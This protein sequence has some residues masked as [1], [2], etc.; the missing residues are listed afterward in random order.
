MSQ[1]ILIYIV[2]AFLSA[3]AFNCIP[4]N[5]NPIK[6]IFV[7]SVCGLLLSNLLINTCMPELFEKFSDA[8]PNAPTSNNMDNNVNTYANTIANTIA[9]ANTN[10]N[11]NT[12]ANII[13][14]T[15]ANANTNANT[16]T[17]SN[18]NI[19]MNT[20][21]DVNA[22]A[23]S[24][25][26]ANVLDSIL[27]KLDLEIKTKLLSYLSQISNQ[28]NANNQDDNT[29]IEEAIA[30]YFSKGK[31]IDERGMINNIINSD[32]K[33]NQLSPESLQPL[34]SYDNTFTNKWDHGFTYLSTDKWAPSKMQTPPVCKTEKQCP[35]CPIT[36]S[37]YPIGLMEFDN[38]RKVLG[39]DNIN[40]NYI[41]EKLNSQQ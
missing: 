14:N 1:K 11:A 29:R 36:T 32:M 19:N 22:N 18:A 15:I 10:V 40:I 3:I 17:V 31:Y 7:F 5:V 20:N 13:A 26:V 27:S 21:P 9:N 4:E 8:L 24:A 23:G 2:I 28:P 39:P 41:K 37:G 38:S 12:I 6:N 33:Y 34:G 35:I 16:N 25:S 30:K